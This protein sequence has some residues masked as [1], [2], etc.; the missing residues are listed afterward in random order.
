MVGAGRNRDLVRRGMARASRVLLG[1]PNP[2]VDR[3]TLLAYFVVIAVPLGLLAILCLCLHRSDDPSLFFKDENMRWWESPVALIVS[4][5]VLSVPILLG[6]GVVWSLS[7]ALLTLG[8]L[9]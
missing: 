8:W 3:M 2:G 4:I 1:A 6:I 5:F 9:E 7:W